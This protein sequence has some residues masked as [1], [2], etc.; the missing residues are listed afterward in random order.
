MGDTVDA[1]VD[2]ARRALIAK[3]HTTTHM[4]NHALR[5]ALGVACDQRGSLCDAEKLRFD[6][7]YNKPLTDVQLRETQ[8]AVNKQIAAALPVRT[9]VAPPHSPPP[10]T[11]HPHHRRA[12][13]RTP[14]RPSR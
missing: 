9:Q 1:S 6:F 10:F 12:A 8:E 7:A 2:Y 4:L 3:N 13:P 5:S 14:H 11:Y